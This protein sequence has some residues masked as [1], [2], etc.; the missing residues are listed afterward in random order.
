[1]TL[2][3]GF[4]LAGV[5]FAMVIGQLLFKLSSAHITADAGPLRLI[6]SLLNWQFIV[7]LA[8]Y[9]LSTVLWVILIKDLPLNRAY[10]FMA[11]SFVLVPIASVWLFQEPLSVR[12]LLGSALL[13]GGLLVIASE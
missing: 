8:F 2:S 4:A 1:M 3:Q 11:L 12:Y 10:P 6:S 13:L 5:V 9:G 7:A